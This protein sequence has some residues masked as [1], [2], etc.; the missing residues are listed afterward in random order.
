MG[1][2]L[3]FVVVG[4]VGE[5]GVVVVLWAVRASLACRVAHGCELSELWSARMAVED[6][7]GE[8]RAAQVAV[9]NVQRVQPITTTAAEPVTPVTKG[10][11]ES[12]S[13]TRTGTVTVTLRVTPSV[14]PSVTLPS[15]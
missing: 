7:D 8:S 10:D 11:G 14:T 3:V 2:L 13:E 5:N 9:D 4:H 1:V 12:R 15:T 6:E